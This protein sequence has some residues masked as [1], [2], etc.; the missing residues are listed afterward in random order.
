MRTI[1]DVK[2]RIASARNVVIVYPYTYVN[3]YNC[4][5]PIAAEYLQAG[6][7]A[8]G[9]R[10]LLLDMR[11]EDRID[12][13]VRDADIVC[14]YG[15]FED[16]TIFGRWGHHVIDRVLDIVPPGTPVIAGGTG[17]SDPDAALEAHGRVDLIL[18][19]SPDHPI[20]ELLAGTDPEE[21]PNVVF[22][23]PE[24][25][26]RT[27]RVVYPLSEKIYPRR[28][29]RNPRYRYHVIG[30][31]VDLIRAG[32]GCNYRCRFCYQ[33]GKDSDGAFLRWQGRSA[34]SVCRELAEISAPIV[35]WIDDDM[36][37]DMDLLDDIAETLIR[38]RIRKLYIG[39]GRLDHV[40][41]GGV[42]TLIKL[43]KAG[44]L[45]LGFGVES[46]KQE[47]LRFYGKG[48]TIDRIEQAMA[49]MRKTNVLLFCN[50]LFG[51]P[52]ETEEDM[53]EYL[54]FGHKWG[55]DTLVTN[56]L[57]VQKGSTMHEAMHDGDTG[58]PL[59]G[60]ERITGKELERIKL[61]VKFAQRTPPRIALSF[62][63]LYRHQGMVIDPLTVFCSLIETL[64]QGTAV[65][66]T[67]LV[68]FLLR[69]GKRIGANP[70]VNQLLRLCAIVSYPFVR[71]ADR[72][73]HRVDRRFGISTKY[74]AGLFV[75]FK[76]R[77]YEKQKR[78][79]QL[80]RSAADS[81]ATSTN[82]AAH[83]MPVS[84]RVLTE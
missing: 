32:V 27:P 22:R 58:E 47:T 60:M 23:T 5:P 70:V 9:K 36:T 39:T 28:E 54:W 52:G 43:E 46:L 80:K 20:R 53:I 33:Y 37:T 63:K 59:P 10:A 30:L 8:S 7:V 73:F 76:E 26:V 12:D 61:T 42:D 81:G 13:R 51:S 31:E 18:R 14:L 82:G 50:F 48:L 74:V 40:L 16:C 66:K 72:L 44:L 67:L 55:V 38:K 77:V 56:R 17:F 19:G 64:I 3:P 2:G 78:R 84:E 24:G 6:I 4:L 57:R 69:S 45:V 68:P 41:K 62:I 35:Y 25:L 65:E 29:L 1:A 11:F 34:D 75:S 21:T 49:M 71:V 15:Y 79:A 83:S